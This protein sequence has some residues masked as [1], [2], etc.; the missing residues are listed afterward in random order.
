M[1]M[2]LN[3][4]DQAQLEE[5][6][7]ILIEAKNIGFSARSSPIEPLLELM[8][9]LSLKLKNLFEFGETKWTGK[10]NPVIKF[11]EKFVDSLG[12]P[13]QIT[14][15]FAKERAQSPQL[16]QYFG[17]LA[18]E[19]LLIKQRHEIPTPFHVEKGGLLRMPKKISTKSY[20]YY[21]RTQ[22]KSRN[23]IQ[24]G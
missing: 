23:S 4:L 12:N 24:K 20:H 11:S 8:I 1:L 18:E 5:L 3:I 6:I 16:A 14:L 15:W 19:I 10:K 21:R 7:A 9:D 2:N 17:K 22:N 13:K